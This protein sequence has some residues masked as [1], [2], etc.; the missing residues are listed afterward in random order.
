MNQFSMT[1]EMDNIYP[2]MTVDI[3]AHLTTLFAGHQLTADDSIA[4]IIIPPR[5]ECEAI[6]GKSYCPNPEDDN[7]GL[8]NS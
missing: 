8:S 2:S 1:L 6:Y 4:F 3:S 7:S 5:D